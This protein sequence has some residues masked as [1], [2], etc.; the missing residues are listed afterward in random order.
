MSQTYPL[1]T[2]ARS[3]LARLTFALLLSAPLSAS[4]E[5]LT[6]QW[7]EDTKL[8]FT[9]PLRW[10]ERNWLQF[11]ASLAAIGVAHEYD[12]NVRDHFAASSNTTSGPRNDPSLR[13]AAP[14]AAILAGTWALA[15]AWDDR[16]GYEEGRMMVEAGLFSVLS[17]ELAKYAGGRRRPF[18][19][20]SVDDWRHGGD[21]FPSLH[22][23]AAFAIGT[24]LAESGGDDY[25]WLRRLLGYG[26][27]AGTG[28]ARVEHGA[29]WLSDTV[30]GA[31]L[32]LATAQFTLN[33]RSQRASDASVAVL[34]QPGGFRLT[35]TKQLDIR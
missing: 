1:R 14:T 20:A 29:H 21:S 9:A 17:T 33:R 30:A 11:G 4:A 22:V 2:E 35:Y 7:V 8:Y 18:E 27:A 3:T 19:T 23:S 6:H 13:D 25:R 15:F 32:G 16:A 24:V 28:Y 26:I 34:P 12:S 5:T 10:D 31:A